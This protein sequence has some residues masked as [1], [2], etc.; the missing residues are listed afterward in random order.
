M[1]SSAI[2]ILILF[3]HSVQTQEDKQSEGE[4]SSDHVYGN[5]SFSPLKED[6]G[7]VY[8]QDVKMVMINFPLCDKD[9]ISYDVIINDALTAKIANRTILGPIDN[10]GTGCHGIMVGVHGIRLGKAFIDVS[11]SYENEDASDPCNKEV[12]KIDAYPVVVMRPPKLEGKIFRLG[13]SIF[14]VILNFGFGCSLNLD[15]VKEILKK[16]IAP[17]VGFCCQYVMMALLDGYMC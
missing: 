5:F 14:L 11:V 6:F 8:E 13:V 2:L 7:S 15:I 16:P 9:Y 12:T 17:V 1:R 3:L 4:Q 10:P